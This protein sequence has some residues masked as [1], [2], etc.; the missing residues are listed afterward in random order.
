MKNKL[1]LFWL[2]TSIESSLTLAFLLLIPR[3]PK[4]AW[5][6]GY[7]LPRVVLV[8]INIFVLAISVWIT[9]KA[10]RVCAF[11]SKFIIIYQKITNYPCLAFIIFACSISAAI[12]GIFFVG[13]WIFFSNDIGYEALF[14]RPQSIW[15]KTCV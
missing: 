3:D 9:I 6:L 12:L 11:E 15:D 4:N 10:R 1:Y 2:L 5:L 8:L 13:F 14:V 7:S